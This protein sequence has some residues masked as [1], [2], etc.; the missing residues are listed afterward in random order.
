M[1]PEHLD[2]GPLSFNVS[3]PLDG[4]LL[5]RI[6]NYVSDQIRYPV[7]RLMAN[8]TFFL[9]KPV[10]FLKRDID[11]GETATVPDD[12]Y[13][14]LFVDF[15]DEQSD[16][17]SKLM[18]IRLTE[19]H[20]NKPNVPVTSRPSEPQ[21]D[22]GF[23]IGDDGSDEEDEKD[24]E[25]LEDRTPA[26]PE[27][28]AAESGRGPPI[29]DIHPLLVSG[30][31]KAQPQVQPNR[32]G[33]EELPNARPSKG[34]ALSLS[35]PGASTDPRLPENQAASPRQGP[36]APPGDQKPEGVSEEAIEPQ[37]DEDERQDESA[38]GEEEEVEDVQGYLEE[39]EKTAGL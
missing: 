4:D 25:D 8:S 22:E 35:P 1:P 13:M 18:K 16:Y 37:Q 23:E 19:R 24:R 3:I 12:F 10:R 29:G 28:Q 34:T 17:H 27:K 21:E 14:D 9:N 15:S 33:A 36:Q 11:F 6:R 26:G 39:L 20:L 2:S 31:P 38:S 5:L 7:L 30:P 32:G